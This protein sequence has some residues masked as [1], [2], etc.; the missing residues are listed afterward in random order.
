MIVT[1]AEDEDF[2]RN[3]FKVSDKKTK[4]PSDVF[5]PFS[6]S[7][8]RHDVALGDV[9]PAA[10]A[11]LLESPKKREVLFFTPRQAESL[12][13]CCSVV[14]DIVGGVMSRRRRRA[15]RRGFSG[16]GTRARGL[17][18][19][20]GWRHACGDGDRGGQKGERSRD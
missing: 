11:Q 19:H 13:R 10:L 20:E 8:V 16:Q 3:V 6:L 12:R 15:P 7:Y 5:P 14:G 9:L 18:G 4:N 17:V 1:G 2:F